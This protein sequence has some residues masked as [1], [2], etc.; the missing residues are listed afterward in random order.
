MK[1]IIAGLVVI[2]VLVVAVL[3]LLQGNAEPDDEQHEVGVIEFP[4]PAPGA[5]VFDMKYR[6]LNGSKDE[7]RYNSYWGFG[8]MGANK[9][10]FIRQLKKDIKELHIVCNPKF[11]K[12]QYSAVEVKDKKAVAFYFDLNADGKVSDNEKIQPIP[13][14]KSSN[15]RGSEF[16]TPDFIVNTCDGRQVPFRALL[17]VNFY[18]DS[19]RNKVHFQLFSM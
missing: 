15:S 12:A 9:S 3:L 14:E 2:T 8:G 18:D 13:A 10:P 17:Q 16:V 1:K 6:G 5:I 7:L 4:E 11:G 19:S